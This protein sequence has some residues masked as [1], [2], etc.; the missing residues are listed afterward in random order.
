MASHL[1]ASRQ[2]GC[3]C[4]DTITLVSSRQQGCSLVLHVAWQLP[5]L[6]VQA[7]QEQDSTSPA[8]P[9]ACPVAS[10][11]QVFQLLGLRRA[12]RLPWR[13]VFLV[14]EGGLGWLWPN[15]GSESMLPQPP[16]QCHCP[17]LAGSPLPEPESLGMF[18]LLKLL[19]ACTEGCCEQLDSLLL[20]I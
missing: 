1:D 6:N 2:Q 19:L 11:P 7:I 16:K 15:R 5:A 9:R 17:E 18:S 14:G 4:V 20:W 10:Q 13:A 3:G 12:G 8:V